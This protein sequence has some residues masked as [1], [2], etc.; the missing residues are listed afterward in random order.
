MKIFEF[1]GSSLT[2]YQNYV[3]SFK[4]SNKKNLIFRIYNRLFHKEL[5]WKFFIQNY[6]D[7]IIP[8]KIPILAL[9]C[10]TKMKLRYYDKLYNK[11]S[12]YKNYHRQ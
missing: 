10:S 6:F 1:F 4:W 7:K 12:S 8:D 5:R 11:M 3:Q 9:D 2:S